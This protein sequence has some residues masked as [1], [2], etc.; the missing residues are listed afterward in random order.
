MDK[1]S[2][3][4]GASHDSRDKIVSELRTVIREAEALL[5]EKAD[6][7]EAVLSQA[8][9]RISSGVDAMRKRLDQANLLART[10]AMAQDTDRYVQD[11]AWQSVSVGALAGLLI[12]L[13]IARR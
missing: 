12:G 11:H 10:R 4:N 9:D 8:R 5:H 13:L 6:Q 2:V 7:G 1:P 3:G